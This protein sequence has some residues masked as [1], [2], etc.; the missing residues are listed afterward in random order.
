MGA[1]CPAGRYLTAPLEEGELDAVFHVVHADKGFLN[2][3]QFIALLRAIGASADGNLKFELDLFHEFD[4]EGSGKLE[5]AE[6]TRG[7]Q[8]YVARHGVDSPH[9]ADI[10]RG[11]RHYKKRGTVEL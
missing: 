9:V 7:F 1:T 3:M 4:V 10:I 8:K 2:T 5:K 6:F 11:V